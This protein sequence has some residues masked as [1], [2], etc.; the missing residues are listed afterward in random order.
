MITRSIQGV[1]KKYPV[2]IGDE[3]VEVHPHDLRRTYARIW[4][5]MGGDLVGLQQNLGHA[6]LKTTLGYIGL[7][8]AAKRQPPAMYSPPHWDKLNGL[9]VQGTIKDDYKQND[10]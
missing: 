9:K 8:D 1:I 2:M 3:L 5:D 6:D 4:Y 7:L 10:D